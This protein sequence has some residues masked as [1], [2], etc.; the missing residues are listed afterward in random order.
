MLVL[1][2]CSSDSGDESGAS[3]AP[4][5]SAGDE[6]DEV[7]DGAVTTTTDVMRP[8]PTVAPSTVAGQ[9]GSDDGVIEVSPTLAPP[10][11]T[12]VDPDAPATTASPPSTELVGDP[13]PSSDTTVPPPP[14]TAA[15]PPPLCDRLAEFEVAAEIGGL[16]GADVSSDGSGVDVCRFTAGSS[17][18]EVTTIPAAQVRDVW[19]ERE[20]IEPVAEVG[21]D[22]VGIDGFA[23]PAGAVQS[24]GYTV[25]LIG[26]R[27]GAVIAVRGAPD[28]QVMASFV[29]VFVR[30]V[31]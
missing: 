29:G 15:P 4:P 20:G 3:S 8:V 22:A 28:D 25:A 11:P 2:A 18:V 26:G 24:D 23:D 9:T 5:T 13:A 7:V 27:D 31:V 1:A 16:A 12:P 19:F 17:V 14:P 6:T 30:Q 10:P 21:G